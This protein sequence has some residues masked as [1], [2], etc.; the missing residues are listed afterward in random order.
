MKADEGKPCPRSG[1]TTCSAPSPSFPALRV[2]SKRPKGKRGKP[3]PAAFIAGLERDILTLERELR[4]GTYRPGGYVA[5]RVGD[6]SHASSPWAGR[7]VLRRPADPQ[8]QPRRHL[9]PDLPPCAEGL[10]ARQPAAQGGTVVAFEPGGGATV[11]QTARISGNLNVVVQIQGDGNAVTLPDQPHLT[12]LARH[13][14]KREPAKLLDLLNPYTC[15][16]PLIGRD[17]QMADLRAWLAADRSISVR[18]LTGRAGAGKTRLA[19]ELCATADVDGWFAGF[20]TLDELERFA[21]LQNL[22]ALG[23]AQPTLAVIDYAAGKVRALRR[24]LEALAENQSDIEKP[25]RLLLLERHGA[26]GEGWWRDLAESPGG[27][28][29]PTCPTYSTRRSQCRL[30]R[31]H[32][33]TNG[34]RFFR[35]SMTFA[36]Q[37]L[38]KP[39]LTPPAAGRCRPTPRRTTSGTGRRR[40]WSTTCRLPR[41]RCAQPASASSRPT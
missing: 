16:V 27:G 28:R 30:P 41:T 29:W 39:P 33:W 17:A 15:P 5:I 12:L 11:A 3:M 22:S 14:R 23:W 4:S 8:R 37:I 6:P 24:W 7:P 25:L 19:Q 35:S 34:E 1:M 13:R 26:R 32:Q 36:A 21:G 38:T 18:C 9:E 10:P 20:V 31:W 40:C 2:A